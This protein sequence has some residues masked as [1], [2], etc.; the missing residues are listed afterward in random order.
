MGQAL[1]IN[2]SLTPVKIQAA[3]GPLLDMSPGS[4]MMLTEWIHRV[5]SLTAW[6]GSNHSNGAGK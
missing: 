4:E 3:G 2:C 6:L 5:F 1:A